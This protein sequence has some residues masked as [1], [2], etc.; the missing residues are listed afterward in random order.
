MQPAQCKTVERIM[1]TTHRAD[2][3]SLLRNEFRVLESVGMNGRFD[4]DAERRVL[5]IAKED[6]S[7]WSAFR[8]GGPLPAHPAA[9][10]ML[11]RVA[12]AT[13][14]LAALADRQVAIGR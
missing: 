7:S 5:L 11:Q 3:A 9:P 2:A 12:A 1:N 4:A 13:Y 6:W 14:R 10:V 8:Q